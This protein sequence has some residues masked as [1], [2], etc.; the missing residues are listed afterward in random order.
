MNLSKLGAKKVLVTAGPTYEPID[1]VRFIG[2]HSS[3]KMGYELCQLLRDAGAEVFL[4]TGPTSLPK[5]AGIIIKE[6]NTAKEMYEASKAIFE[7]MDIAILAAA[8][9]DYTPKIIQNKKIKKN[10]EVLTLELVKTKDI[11]KELGTIKNKNQILIGFALE[12]DNEL[13]NARL[14][15]VKKNFDFIVLNSLQNKDTCFGSNNNQIIIVDE[16]KEL[17]FEFKS[18]KKVALDIINHIEN[19]L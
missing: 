1:P 9:A 5:P 19:L 2:N 13:E 11:A 14:K 17:Y 15:R 12:T 18:K 16:H 10:D 4:V 8:V 7:K 3:G 6:V